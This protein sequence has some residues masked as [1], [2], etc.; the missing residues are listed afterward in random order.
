M[1]IRLHDD[2]GLAAAGEQIRLYVGAMELN[3]IP[4]HCAATLTSA[5][6]GMCRASAHTRC[7]NQTTS[8]IGSSFRSYEYYFVDVRKHTVVNHLII[9]EVVNSNQH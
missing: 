6:L 3:A 8:Q 9:G 2:G 5:K 1:L 7:D 4:R